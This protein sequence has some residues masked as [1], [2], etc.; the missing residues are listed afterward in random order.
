M[1]PFIS[2]GGG[3]QL[4]YVFLKASVSQLARQAPNKTTPL[5]M[6]HTHSHCVHDE[7]ANALRT[8]RKTCWHQPSLRDLRAAL[9]QKRP[10]PRSSSPS[11]GES[12]QA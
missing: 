11:M 1:F 8:I 9:A 4:Q 12:E 5:C 7:D 10:W 2:C 3:K 6:A